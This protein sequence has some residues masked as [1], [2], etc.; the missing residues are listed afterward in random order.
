MHPGVVPK[1]Y[2]YPFAAG[3]VL[4][5]RAVALDGNG[6][7]LPEYLHEKAVSFDP[8]DI[9]FFRRKAK[10]NPE[11][12]EGGEGGGR[13]RPGAPGQGGRDPGRRLRPDG[14]GH[15]RRGSDGRIRPPH[16]ILRAGHGG[17]PRPPATRAPPGGGG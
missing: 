1:G 12:W 16:R 14:P 17:P 13:S 2:A 3:S 6:R 10:G 9:E 8:G 11:T 4:E 7:P 15:E 5:V